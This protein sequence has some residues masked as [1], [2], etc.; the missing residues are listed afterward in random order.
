MT[1]QNAVNNSLTGQTGTYL[2][3]GSIAPTIFSPLINQINDDNN[4]E[5]LAFNPIGSAVNYF[6]MFNNSTTN[7]PALLSAGSDTNIGMTFKTKGTGN[8]NFSTDASTNAIYFSTGTGY[9]H[10]T[11]FSFAN[12]SAV[13]TI[14][15]P[16]VTGTVVTTSG[17]SAMGSGSYIEF[18][19]GTATVVSGAC[20]LNKQVMSITTEN[21]T[22]AQYAT[23][24]FTINNTFCS[25]GR[26]VGA[27]VNVIGG[28]NTT[29]GIAVNANCASSFISVQLTNL[30]S[31]ALNGN[32]VVN[33]ILY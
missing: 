7:P 4:N 33:V 31:A 18:D 32:V 25:T 13:R 30:N 23:Y 1:L 10:L 17:T 15:W 12:T 5:I 3:V 2:F 26:P 27:T 8:F 20:T 24:S 11:N 9:Q 16:D 28:T 19:S 21:L 6:S 22:T 14:T 29:Q